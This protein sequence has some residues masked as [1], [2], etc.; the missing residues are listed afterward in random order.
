MRGWEQ[1]LP[2]PCTTV[3]DIEPRAVL[4]G[5][6]GRVAAYPAEPAVHMRLPG[7]VVVSISVSET[8]WPETA[9]LEGNGLQCQLC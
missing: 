2:V 4:A 7:C 9:L 1:A 5:H 3:Q 6:V 8:Y